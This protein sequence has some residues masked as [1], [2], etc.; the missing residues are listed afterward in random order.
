MLPMIS[1]WTML[2]KLASLLSFGTLT[3]PEP[4]LLLSRNLFMLYFYLLCVSNVLVLLLD[5]IKS[6]SLIV[7]LLLLA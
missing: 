7:K 1:G 5:S 6:S 3:E 2:K 4:N